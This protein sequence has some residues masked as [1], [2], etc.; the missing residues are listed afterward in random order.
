MEGAGSGC[1]NPLHLLTL[2][3]ACKALPS[4][5]SAQALHAQ[6]GRVCF[7]QGYVAQCLAYSSHSLNAYGFNERMSGTKELHECVSSDVCP[8]G[9]GAVW[10]CQAP[11]QMHS[12]ELPG[13]ETFRAVRGNRA[14]WV[15]QGR[16]E[17]GAWLRRGQG[18]PGSWG[19]R[20]LM[21]VMSKGPSGIKHWESPRLWEHGGAILGLH[22][23][24]G[25]AVVSS[26]HPGL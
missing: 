9:S 7:V 20:S 4:K 19:G 10:V 22:E 11:S 26:H 2:F 18:K 13:L 3:E 12:L 16:T 24:G 1:P 21:A 5:T 6:L 25:R 8:L 14:A 17:K 15:L 23:G